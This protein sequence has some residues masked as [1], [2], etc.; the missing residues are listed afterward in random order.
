MRGENDTPPA[1]TACRQP[2]PSHSSTQPLLLAVLV[3]IRAQRLARRELVER[4]ARVLGPEQRAEAEHPR[5]HA[6]GVVVFIFERRLAEVDAAHPAW[7]TTR[8]RSAP[9]VLAVRRQ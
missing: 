8:G 2:S 7:C 3:V 9:D 4:C 6:V 5:A 1:P